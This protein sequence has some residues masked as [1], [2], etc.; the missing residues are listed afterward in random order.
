MSA[1]TADTTF[2]RPRL[3]MIVGVFLDKQCPVLTLQGDSH[4]VG[5]NDPSLKSSISQVQ[6]GSLRGELSETSTLLLGAGNGE[7]AFNPARTDTD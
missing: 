2:R 7:P 1:E 3:V 4:A 5:C 6:P